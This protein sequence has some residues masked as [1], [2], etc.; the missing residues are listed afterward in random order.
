MKRPAT[1]FCLLLITVLFLIISFPRKVTVLSMIF[2]GKIIAPEAS[3]ILSHYCFGNGDTLQLNPEYFQRSQVIQKAI[4]RMKPG[5]EK[6]VWVHQPDDW[7]LSYALNGFSLRCE[8]D[9]YLVYQ[10]I[11]FDTTGKVYTRLN[12]GFT[13]IKVYDN[14]VHAF[15]CT[16]FM[17]VARIPKNSL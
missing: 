2:L 8:K 9:H 11:H 13:T 7:R 6:T 1:I 14:L 15:D 10:Y 3:I 16:P 17:A 12:L 4:A 5:Q